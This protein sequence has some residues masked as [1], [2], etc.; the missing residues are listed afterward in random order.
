MLALLGDADLSAGRG[1]FFSRAALEAAGPFDEARR[2]AMDYDHWIRLTERSS[3]RTLSRTLARFRYDL[4]SISFSPAPD[5][6][7]ETLAI[8]RKYWGR[9]WTAA[10]WGLQ[11]SYLWY[12]QRQR[13]FRWMRGR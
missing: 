9:P 3:V 11:A 13:F 2:Y 10:F 1:N 5:Q 7:E 12:Y 6:W 8:S 4:G